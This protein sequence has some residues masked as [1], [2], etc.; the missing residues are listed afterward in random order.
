M[1]SSVQSISARRWTKKPSVEPIE[2]APAGPAIDPA[3]MARLLNPQV[4]L[5]KRVSRAVTRFLIVFCIGVVTTLAWQSYGARE[6][7]ASSS[8]RLG[9]LAPPAA[10]AV[11]AVALAPDRE[12]LKAISFRLADVQQRVDQIAAQFVAGQEQATRDITKLHAAE[13][14]T[15][16]N[17][18][19]LHADEQ[20]LLENIL[21]EHATEQETLANILD[22]ISAP[23]PRPAAATVRKPPPAPLAPPATLA[24]P[25]R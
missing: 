17:L 8:P 5:G 10:P 19:K 14:E 24:P 20:E 11:Q 7:I 22:K 16:G 21:K 23:P 9:W 2:E 13:Q 4:P 12:D 6:M 1:L 3:D 18:F 15:L 25:V